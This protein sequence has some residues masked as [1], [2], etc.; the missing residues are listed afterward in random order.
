MKHAYVPR[1]TSYSLSPDDELTNYTADI[2]SAK[3]K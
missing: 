3:K 2:Q 1:T